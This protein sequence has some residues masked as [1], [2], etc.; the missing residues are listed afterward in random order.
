M[1]IKNKLT[2]QFVVLV[3]LILATTLLTIY[4]FSAEYQGDDFYNRLR[5]KAL[6]SAKLLIELNEIDGSMLRRLEHDNPTALPFEKILIFNKDDVLIFSTDE[7]H[8]L[9]INMDVLGIIKNHNEAH[10][11]QG[12]YDIIGLLFA[13]ENNNFTVVVGAIDLYG[14]SRL[15]NLT[16]ILIAAFLFT[17]VVLFIMGRIFSL[18]ALSPMTQVVQ[19]VSGISAS[20]LNIR[21][22]E[23]NGRD[24]ISKLARTFNDMLERLEQSFITQKKFI[25]N[26]SHELRTPLTAI[27]SQIEVTLLKERETKDYKEC[28]LSVQEDIRKMI[29]LTNQLLM[30]A[31]ADSAGTRLPMQ[32]IRLDELLWQARADLIKMHPDYKVNI[33]LS[34]L[35]DDEKHLTIRGYDSLF[36]NAIINL[37]DNGCKYSEDHKVSVMLEP[38]EHW[39]KIIFT[40]NGIGI[41]KEDLI[42]VTQPFYR[43]S[44]TTGYHGLGLGLS[45]V[46]KIFKTHH[47]EMKIYSELNHGTVIDILV[48]VYTK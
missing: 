4:V 21:V 39:I 18:R 2:L 23:G 25:D 14:K 33:T 7:S 38:M 26:A 22:D 10:F 9:N 36:R 31:R 41:S 5:N 28:L 42:R 12:K 40:D 15:K 48:P 34:E 24:E 35:I 1:E 47:C 13:D 27:S 6:N 30:I 37:M 16:V 20:N 32:D 19:Q 43:G 44:N 45:L 3:S 17:I 11:K 8:I 46:N 29:A